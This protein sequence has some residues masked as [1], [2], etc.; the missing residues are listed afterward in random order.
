MSWSPL[1]LQNL[2]Y[3][4]ASLYRGA[5]LPPSGTFVKFLS[6]C[7]ASQS[8]YDQ[9]IIPFVLLK[10][11]REVQ[12]IIR[13]SAK[14][15]LK[16]ISSPF[17]QNQSSTFIFLCQSFGGE[18]QNSF[19]QDMTNNPPVLSGLHDKLIH[20]AGDPNQLCQLEKKRYWD[21]FALLLFFSF[22]LFLCPPHSPHTP[23][24]L[25]GPQTIHPFGF[26]INK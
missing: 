3:L 2:C 12:L 25:Q 1:S 14:R 23:Q 22:T 20:Q 26:H 13:I 24:P 19:I 5:H 7:G 9:I 21:K 11:N 10:I 18:P 17:R 15:L 8:L 16:T 6:N 4:A